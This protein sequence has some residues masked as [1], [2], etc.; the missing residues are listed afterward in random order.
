[1]WFLDCR[2]QIYKTGTRDKVI[3]EML[4][5][6]QMECNN[7]G[8]WARW[9]TPA[10]LTMLSSATPSS[11][12]GITVAHAYAKIVQGL[13]VALAAA[14]IHGSN[15]SLI[16][17]RRLSPAVTLAAAQH[18]STTPRWRLSP[19]FARARYH[20]RRGFWHDMHCGP[21]WAD[22]TP[23]QHWPGKY[24][25]EYRS[26]VPTAISYLES[27]GSVAAW[28]CSVDFASLDA[29]PE[30]LFKLFLDPD[31]D[32]GDDPNTIPAETAQKYFVDYT[33]CLREYIE[34]WLSNTFPRSE[35]LRVEY[36]FSTPT[37][38]KSPAFIDTIERL[39]KEAGYSQARSTFH[40]SLTEAEAAAVYAARQPY[41]QGDIIMVCDAGGGTTD[42]NI[43]KFSAAQRDSTELEQ[44]LWVEGQAV[45]SALIDFNVEQ[46]IT[47][48]LET[49]QQHLRKAP[50]DTCEAMVRDRLLPFKHAFGTDDLGP[51]DLELDV[52]GLSSAA[53]FPDARIFDGKM[54]LTHGELGT[55]FD[56]Q[57]TKMIDLV[58]DQLAKLSKSFPQDKVAFLVLS[59]GLGSSPYVRKRMKAVFGS[60]SSPASIQILTAAEPQLAVAYGL[61]MDRAQELR[62]KGLVFKDRCARTSYG[63]MTRDLYD[64]KLDLHRNSKISVDPRDGRKWVEGQI[65][66]LVKQGQ[67][68]SAT[69]GARELY[70]TK[71]EVGKENTPWLVQIVTSEVPATKLP[72]SFNQTAVA[73]LCTVAALLDTKLMKLKNKHWYEKGPQYWLAE[74]ELRVIVG[75]ADLKFELWDIRGLKC[76]SR[77]HETVEVSFEGPESGEKTG[78]GG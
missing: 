70:R 65:H 32:R 69:E 34:K 63:I 28:G 68:V 48:R 51:Q 11:A 14:T 44:L 30:D 36:L 78:V 50:E 66:W 55:I 71:L 26:K 18:G 67:S 76:Y 53:S 39:V 59:G 6:P 74:F 29:I 12:N 52:P 10:I 61:V 15:Q 1:M 2:S 37:T 20:H 21:A 73:K 25:T 17:S 58:N 72:S 43:L 46:M 47:S 35:E 45:G 75:A 27:D 3:E 62:K 41:R 60:E 49:I 38:W 23:L 42:L 64:P 16:Y 24:G 56:A 19:S 5:G 22:P 33:R 40:I 8:R 31:F 57:V 54:L 77:E 13:G 7:V 4:L 9:C